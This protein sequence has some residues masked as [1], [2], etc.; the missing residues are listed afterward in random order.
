MK[1]FIGFKKLSSKLLV[2]YLLLGLIPLFIAGI[3]S[4]GFIVKETANKMGM[5][6]QSQ[7]MNNMDKID[8]NL[9]E[10]YGDAQAFA[11]HARRLANRKQA[12][13]A[14]NFFMASYRCYDLM[15]IADLNGTITVVNT[16]D[17][18][19]RNVDTSWLLG[20]SVKGQ[21]WFERIRNGSIGQG[22]SYAGDMEADPWVAQVTGGAGHSLNF[23]APIF[24]DSGRLVG[25]WSNRASRDRII[26]ETMRDLENSLHQQGLKGG[27]AQIVNRRGELID[28]ADPSVILRLNLREKGLK[29][30]EAL[31][32]SKS[33]F[34]EEV[35]LRKKTM[36]VNGYAPSKGHSDFQ[37]FGWGMLVR[38][39][40]A[41]A[42]SSARFLGLLAALGAVAVMA[43]VLGG[44]WVARGITAPIGETVDALE[45]IAAGDLRV[46]PQITQSDETGRL[47]KGLKSMAEKFNQVINEVREGATGITMASSQVS[48]TSQTLSQ[49]TSE[50]ASS[51]E[52]T[53][54]GLKQMSGSVVQNADNS[55]QMEQMVVKGVQNLEE[56]GSAVKE[57]VEAMKMIAE[58]VMIIED[59]A[60]QTNLLALNAAIEAASAGEHGRGF[61]VVATEVRKLA[62]RSQSAAKEI[63]EVSATSVGVAERAGH[64]IAELVPYMKKTVDLVQEVAAVSKDQTNSVTEIS[65]AMG[66]IDQVTQRNASIGEELASTAEEM[67]SQAEGLQQLISFFKLK[68]ETVSGRSGRIRDSKVIRSAHPNASS[69]PTPEILSLATRTSGGA[70]VP[71]KDFTKF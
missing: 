43:I 53:N 4:Y 63:R 28:D 15:F 31:G 1:N 50:Q 34:T 2:S 30:A 14:L 12:V 48:A 35:H 24:D 18:I 58:R 61:A 70:P 66:Q 65:N 59:I 51:V 57:A 64:V 5:M 27:E 17:H 69:Q 39:D 21:D 16:L 3:I 68:E 7:A 60:Y 47:Q 44:L 55:R 11:F 26:G 6:L 29:A 9:F 49:G 23:S 52:K 22:A 71:G 10:R 8:R 45:K 37:G 20:K 40:K 42:V 33:G 62:E 46:D 13:D 32:E 41:N 67:Y 25:V 38:S 54:V 19:G 56:G 36:Y